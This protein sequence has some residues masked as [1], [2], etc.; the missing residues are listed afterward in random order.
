MPAVQYGAKM[1]LIVKI[2][3]PKLFTGKTGDDI[4]T[5]LYAIDICFKV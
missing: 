2:E 3:T 4:D 1:S 5:W